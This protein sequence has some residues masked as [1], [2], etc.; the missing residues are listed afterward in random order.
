MDCLAPT[1]YFHLG[2]QACPSLIPHKF[3]PSCWQAC[4]KLVANNLA[5][6]QQLH[7]KSANKPLQVCLNKLGQAVR[8]HPV[9]KLLMS[10]IITGGSAPIIFQANKWSHWAMSEAKNMADFDAIFPWRLVPKFI[11]ITTDQ[12]SFFEPTIVFTHPWFS[13][14]FFDH[15]SFVKRCTSRIRYSRPWKTTN[16]Y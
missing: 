15:L 14:Y 5:L 1:D 7:Y 10:C 3:V 9:D 2:L 4:Y 16:K 11:V 12:G 6:S 8:T 13:T